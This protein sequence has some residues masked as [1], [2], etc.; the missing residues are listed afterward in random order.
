M[1][2]GFPADRKITL[3]L[4]NPAIVNLYNPGIVK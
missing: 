2:T 4:Y 1:G 3:F